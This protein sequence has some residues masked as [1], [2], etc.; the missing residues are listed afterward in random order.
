MEKADYAEKIN[1]YI[2][3]YIKFGDAKAGSILAFAGVVVSGIASQALPV[4]LE[5]L[6]LGGFWAG[7][8]CAVATIILGLIGHSAYRTLSS[9]VHALSPR[10]PTAEKSLNS[11]P[12]IRQMSFGDYAKA[13]G[14]LNKDD[15]ALEYSKHNHAL[16][17]IA[18]EKFGAI[19]EATDSLR[20][21]LLFSAVFLIFFLI[22]KLA[23]KLIA[24]GGSGI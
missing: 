2:T 19:R 22:V 20:K 12:D 7:A 16:S 11:F 4:F 21:T 24:P 5:T 10:T 6:S 23:V 9:C 18:F 15:I 8:G 14:A 17:G 13:I 3:S 1:S